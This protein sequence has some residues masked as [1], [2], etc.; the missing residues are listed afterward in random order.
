MMRVET[1]Q[2]VGGTFNS[3]LPSDR[4]GLVLLKIGTMVVVALAVLRAQAS[5]QKNDANLTQQLHSALNLA[6]RGD[7]QGAMALDRKILEQNPRFAPAI[8]LK[9]M[10]LEESGQAQE[11]AAAYEEAL[12]L[13]PSDPDLLL[14]TGVYKLTA[15]NTDEAVRLLERCTKILPA[16]GDAHFY[17]AQAYHLK[18]KDELALRAIRVTL[19]S[20]PDNPS[21]WQK[22]GELLCG[23]GDCEGGLSWL[24]KAQK[25]DAT[26][27]RI[28][29]DIAA[30]DYKLLDLA[31][32]AQFTARA[33]QA[34]PDDLAAWQLLATANLKLGNWRDARSAFEKL[35]EY[36]P[37]D[38]EVLLGLGQC[39]LELKNYQSALD[40]L[41]SVLQIDPTR[42]R[43]HFYLS[44]AYAGMGKSEDAQHEAT[45]H[46]L[47]MEQATFARSAADEQHEMPIK[48]HAQ[49]LLAE[50]RE[51][52]ALKLYAE[53]FK[54]TS[55]TAADAYVFVGKLY[56]FSGKAE[57]GLRCLRQA[58][59]MQPTVRGAHTYDGIW[60]LKLGD[61]VRAEGEFDKELANDPSYQLAIAEL[62]EVRYHQER[63]SEAAEQLSKSKITTPEL[64]YQLSD[65]Y[66]H[67]GKTTEAD[68]TAEIAAAYGRNKPEF[69]K[70]LLDLLVRNGQS[71]LATRLSPA[72]AQ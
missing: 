36:K 61:L 22:Y 48:T 64:L 15:G 45:L 19:K 70:Q 49:Q 14:K 12:K 56:L 54:G 9:G 11:A 43:A 21:V 41:Q 67:L 52:E 37:N 40:V 23:T 29:F 7:R 58:L 59:K 5:P 46:Q 6:E 33:V 16:D 71:D 51:D 17:L 26:L 30:T 50:H 65:S 20:S 32:A 62:G 42:L 38:V 57:D 72:R 63:W 60:A 55:A 27:P 39:E 31:G 25:A 1:A 69:M 66:F 24:T 53:Q 35:R 3:F 2:I 18:G 47:M 34:Q 8:K 10:L 68:L 4:R 13:A 28:D 44:K